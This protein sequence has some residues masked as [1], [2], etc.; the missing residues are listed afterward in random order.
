V[1][2]PSSRAGRPSGVGNREWKRRR[3][4]IEP[5][6]RSE[7]AAEVTSEPVIHVLLI[8]ADAGD[9]LLVQEMLAR[10]GSA[11]SCTWASDL[12]GGLQ[13][14]DVGCDCILVDQRPADAQ[15]PNPVT[16]VL[17][18]DPG[19]AVIV[20]TANDDRAVAER[21]VGLG[22]QDFLVKGEIDHEML[23]R[24]IRYAIGRRHTEQSSRQLREAQLLRA[25]NTRLERGLVPRPI[26]H[27]PRLRWSTRYQAGGRRALLGGDFFD[28]VELGDGTLRMVMGDVCGHG[29]D[30]AALG[31][32][33][34]VAWRSL[35]LADQPPDAALEALQRILE[36]ER[37]SEE[38]FATLC[39]I[40]VDP[41]LTEA[42]LR[43]A[44]H[45]NP[46]LLV[47]TEAAEVP[48]GPH[49]PLLGVF[50]RATWPPN[51]VALVEGWTL[52]VFTDGIIEGRN[53][54]NGERLG[55]AC[56][57]RRG[58]QGGGSRPV[59]R[60]ARRRGGVGQR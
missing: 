52:V 10:S 3:Q 31:V 15:G 35:V 49:G 21:A 55:T 48:T 53:G 37:S 4:V 27:N 51:H 57:R 22:A 45:P 12:H 5:Q 6:R 9:A 7:G 20:L 26:I 40:E 24:S 13:V 29:P 25:E 18:R 54:T 58:R 11:Y 41:T 47:G 23:I 50:D 30:E 59:G 60:V 39:D 43:V 32:A 34:R 36:A 44:G 2:D 8:E 19:A 33:L 56:H 14:V 38:T 16:A 1:V 28:A 17:E 46:L 42:W